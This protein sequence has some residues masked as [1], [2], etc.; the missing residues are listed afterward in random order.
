MQRIALLLTANQDRN[1]RV[2]EHLAR[3]TAQD[4][5]ARATPPMRSHADQIAAILRGRVDDRLIDDIA[6]FGHFFAV[7]ALS[8]AKI[9]DQAENPLGFF[10]RGFLEDWPN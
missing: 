8:P 9:F 4:D 5:C 3:F 7:Y 10:I 2:G 6:V 1:F